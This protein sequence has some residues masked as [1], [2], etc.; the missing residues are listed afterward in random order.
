MSAMIREAKEEIGIEIKA[1]NLKLAHVMH[2]QSNS[3]HRVDFFSIATNGLVKK[4]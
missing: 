4:K 3:E 2:R 1:K